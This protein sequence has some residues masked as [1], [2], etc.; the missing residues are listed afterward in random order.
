MIGDRYDLVVASEV[1]YYD[2]ERVDQGPILVDVLGAHVAAGSNT[3]V[4]I[5]YKH[6]ELTPRGFW[7]RA[8]SMGF[9]LERLEDANGRTV[10]FSEAEPPSAYRGS[11][12]VPL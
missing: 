11:Q 7:E 1:I 2:E 3:E 8:A 5:A 10:A 4:L 6:R 9:L 12:F